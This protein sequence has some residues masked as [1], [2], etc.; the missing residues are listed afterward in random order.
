M[1]YI[2]FSVLIITLT[3]ISCKGDAPEK[4]LSFAEQVAAK[5]GI[6]SWDQV[7]E[8][9]F[10]F[11]VEKDTVH[12]VRA[13][14]WKPKTG[15]VTEV[16]NGDTVSYNR[17][18]VDEKSLQADKGFINDTYWLLAPFKLVWDEGLEIDSVIRAE[19]P[20]SRDT[21]NKLTI[22]YT[23]DQGYTPGD[24][25][26]LYLDDDL[27]VKEWVYRQANKEGNCMA[28]TW[29]DYTTINGIRFATRHRNIRDNVAIYFTGITVKTTEN[30]EVE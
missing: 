21:L 1:K 18:A 9:Q 2:Y 26:D 14:T 16:V 12:F 8:L 28:T 4:E 29:E 7:E 5:H 24:A 25:Y 3:V 20:I 27:L 22:T 17:N 23:G 15:E 30:R 13:W 19:A 10:T 6:S 11:N